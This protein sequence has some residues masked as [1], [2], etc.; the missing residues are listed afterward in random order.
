MTTKQEALTLLDTYKSDIFTTGSHIQLKYNPTENLSKIVDS[1]PRKT[2]ISVDGL[3]STGKGEL[4]R[5][6]HELGIAYVYSG[7]VWRAM[8]YIFEDSGEEID[9][10]NIQKHTSSLSITP[11]HTIKLF[12]KG[13][14]L[15]YTDLKNPRIDTAINKYNKRPDI[16]TAV[17]E[18]LS[19]F[20]VT[21]DQPFVLDLRG[22][23]PKFIR[24]LSDAGFN[25]IRILL[26]CEPEQKI[27]RRINEYLATG[28]KFDPERVSLDILQRD[29][30]DIKALS[31]PRFGGIVHPES[32]IIDT[33]ELTIEEVFRT[34]L[35]CIKNSLQKRS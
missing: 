11:G 25:I 5:H 22:A 10:S 4:S 30:N 31:D 3:A 17:D 2:V 13:S 24:D 34:S 15:G 33:T 18:V 6:I 20:M 1:L 32:Y 8:T 28:K 23:N 29:L 12:Y 21:Y 35:E 27:K 19:S 16:R 14:Q 7:L 26:F 9:Q